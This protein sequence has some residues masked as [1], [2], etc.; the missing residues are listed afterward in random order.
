M[1][2]LHV[3]VTGATGKQGGAVARRLIEKGHRVRALTRKPESP[4]AKTLAG[5]GVEV[6]AGDLEDRGSID[7]ALAGLDAIFAVS[8]PFEAGT[9]AETRQ[10]VDAADAAKAAGAHLVYSSVANADRATGIPHFDSKA[11]VERHIA[12]IG[13]DATIIAPA[14]FMDNLSFLRAQ[15]KD[16]V[17]ASALTPGRKLAQVA[18]SDIGAVAVAALEDRRRFVGKR[19]DLGADEPSGEESVAILS[20]VTGRRLSYFQLPLDVVRGAMGE[21][22]VLMY[23]WFEKVGYSVDGAARRDFPEVPWLSFEAWARTQDW[24]AFFAG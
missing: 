12:S 6:T 15:L 1:T 2:K 7:R 14:Y 13:V 21:D 3:L 19:Y 22:A 20:R 10:G 9:G 17:Y 11:E 4:G 16:G 24:E 8:T 18:V 23:Q 5:L